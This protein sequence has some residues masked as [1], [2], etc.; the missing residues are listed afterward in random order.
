[1][2][3]TDAGPVRYLAPNQV[4]SLAAAVEDEEPD[5]LGMGNYDEAAMDRKEIYPARW[6]VYAET[7]DPLGQMREMYTY[8]RAFLMEARTRG[9]GAIVYF[10]HEGELPEESGPTP[11]TT[12]PEP[13]KL[14]ARS[15]VAGGKGR[16]YFETDA[17]KDIGIAPD[18]LKKVDADA[19]TIGYSHVGDI[20]APIY[21]AGGGL[22][23]YLAKDRTA[24]AIAFLSVARGF[25]SWTFLSLLEGDALVGASDA[26]MQTVKKTKLFGLSMSRSGPAELQASVLQRREELRA[27]FGAPRILEGDLKSIAEIWESYASRT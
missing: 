10:A 21:G 6:R 24:A 8:V 11:A 15:L 2:G 23:A 13:S 9:H 22:R 14:V 17:A 4:A 7:F 1:M 26:F 5:E 12:E 18:V 27:R 16:A 19:A 3:V 20:L 25:G